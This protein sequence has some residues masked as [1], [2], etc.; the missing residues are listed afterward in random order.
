[1]QLIKSRLDWIIFISTLAFFIYNWSYVIYPFLTDQGTFGNTGFLITAALISAVCLKQAVINFQSLKHPQRNIFLI[2]IPV[3]CILSL[4]L[5][6]WISNLLFWDWLK[7][8]TNWQINIYYFD[9][10][11][12]LAFLICVILSLSI[13]LTSFILRKH[14]LS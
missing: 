8:Y 2:L 1:M 10:G 14:S 7:F 4:L 13:F 9:Q 6:G 12:F 11:M 5:S 3:F